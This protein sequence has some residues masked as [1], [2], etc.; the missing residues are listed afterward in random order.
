M[1]QYMLNQEVKTFALGSKVYTITNKVTYNEDNI[2]VKKFPKFFHEKGKQLLVEQ[3][4]EQ[5]N[6]EV[7]MSSDSNENII[8]ESNK[9]NTVIVDYNTLETR[10]ELE[11]YVAENNIKVN[12]GN[13]KNIDKIKERIAEVLGK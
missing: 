6:V 9:T 10:E 8:N 2:I 1:K 11:K 3:P 7:S 13:V 5:A 4:I 12:F